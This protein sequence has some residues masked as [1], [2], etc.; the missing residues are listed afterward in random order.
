MLTFNQLLKKYRDLLSTTDIPYETAK[1]FLLEL[2]NEAD[3]DLYMNIDNEVPSTILDKYTLGIERILKHE[4]MNYVLGY[5]WFY[6]YKYFVNKDVLIP[7][8]ETE[9]LV[10]NILIHI[11]EMFKD[12]AVIDA[13]DIGCGSGAIAIAVALEESKVKMIASDISLEAVEVAKINAKANKVDI[14]FFTGDMLH[15][16]IDANKKV[17]VLI[18]NPPYIPQEEELEESVIDYEPHVA[19]FGGEDGLK[20]YKDVFN[21]SPQILKDRAFMAFEIGW[22]QKEVLLNLAHEYFPKAKSE[23]LKDINGKDRMLFIEFNK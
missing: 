7:R 11:D 8:P 4:P 2:C 1:V 23:V 22:N 17:D 6:G 3:Y 21:T 19:L 18:C 16:L 14:E 5:S 9:E 15:P 20:Y 10:S 12:Q 13:C